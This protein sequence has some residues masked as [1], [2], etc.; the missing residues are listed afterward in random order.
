MLSIGTLIS[1]GFAYYVYKDAKERGVDN[2]VL[3]AAGTFLV[4]IIVFPIYYYK[5]MRE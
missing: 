4:W 5:F 3:W 1:L 2:G